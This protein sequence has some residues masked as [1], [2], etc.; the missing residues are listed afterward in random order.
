MFGRVLPG[1]YRF[2]LL[3]KPAGVMLRSVQCGGARVTPDSP[4]QVGDRQKV[5]DCEML[6]GRDPTPE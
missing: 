4:F 3:K 2:K 6:I 1:G 5:P